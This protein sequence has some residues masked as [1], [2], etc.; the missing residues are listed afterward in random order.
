[1][2]ALSMKRRLTLG[3]LGRRELGHDK[4]VKTDFSLEPQRLEEASMHTVFLQMCFH[5][6]MSM[7]VRP[8]KFES[9]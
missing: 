4:Q 5:G 8:C 9:I 1:M 2:R 7:W 6:Y 3:N